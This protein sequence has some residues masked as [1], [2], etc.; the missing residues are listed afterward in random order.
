MSVGKFNGRFSSVE[1]KTPF[2]IGV[3]GGTASGKST[4]C[5]R[6][7]QKLGQVDVDQAE[8]KVV[9]ISQDSFY[10]ELSPA[11]KAKALKGQYN[12]DHPDAF[13]EELIFKTLKEILDG[14][15][16]ILPT[17]DYRTNASSG[18]SITIYPADV[19]LFEGILVFYFPEIRNLFHMKLF[20]DT[21]SDTRLAR[22]VP[23]DINERGRD[24]DQVLHQY[25]NFVKPAF[26]EFCLPTKKH[27]DVIIPRGADNTVAIELI[28]QHIW[29]I[30][31]GPSRE[32]AFHKYQRVNHRRL[33]S[34]ST[35]SP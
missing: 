29:D 5:A 4:V 9:T 20:V 13:D 34:D 10:R 18:S 24:L 23:R 19:V 21:D 22:R 27:A 1:N 25:M 11:E 12:F 7:M 30:L 31:H 3:A 14:K 32:D 28:V 6:I 15:K 35:Q 2:L 26:E 17:Y 8:R 16:V 33:S